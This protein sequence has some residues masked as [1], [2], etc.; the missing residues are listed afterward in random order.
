MLPMSIF[1]QMKLFTVRD[2]HLILYNAIEEN[3]S[4]NQ[5]AFPYENTSTEVVAKGHRIALLL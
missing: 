4:T 5:K 3:I 2:F 1:A